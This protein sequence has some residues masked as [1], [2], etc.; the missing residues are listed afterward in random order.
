M[1]VSEFWRS[2]PTS[3]F[4]PPHSKVDQEVLEPSSPGLQ[5][6]AKPSQLLILNVVPACW[7]QKDGSDPIWFAAF[8]RARTRARNHAP[9]AAMSSK[10][11]LIRAFEW[12][13]EAG[14]D[15][16]HEYEHEKN[17]TP[18]DAV[19]GQSTQGTRQAQPTPS[20]TLVTCV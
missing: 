16:E 11:H 2:I 3:A 13:L 1:Q 20:A 18:G 5:P 6:D 9:L 14:S 15:V 8:S 4:R 19:G 10:K 12:E 7:P 17:A